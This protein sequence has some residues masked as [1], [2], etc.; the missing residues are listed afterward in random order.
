MPADHTN[1]SQMRTAMSHIRSFLIP[2]V[3]AKYSGEGDLKA[4]SS[5]VPDDPTRR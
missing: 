2:G 4:A 5:F 3:L 1:S